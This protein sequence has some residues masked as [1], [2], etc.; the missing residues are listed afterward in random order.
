VHL[1]PQKNQ[2]FVECLAGKSV[3]KARQLHPIIC[4]FIYEKQFDREYPLFGEKVVEIFTEYKRNGTTYRAHPKYNSCGE[5]Y[6]WVMIRFEM[7]CQKKKKKGFYDNDLFLGKILCFLQSKNKSIDA[8]VH[9][10]MAS[11]HSDDG[12][13]V[14]RWNKEYQKDGRRFIPLL[15]CVS[16][17]SFE[18]PCFVVEDKPG[19]MESYGK[20]P[21]DIN[22]GVTL[23]K[24]REKA[25]PQAF[26]ENK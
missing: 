8:I 7:E 17:D 20:D 3:Q 18:E 15:R 10:C 25:W 24:P 11:D 21:D 26:F 12:I 4:D 22:N 23:V 14:E 16:V 1:N 5:W 19:L 13:L 2:E 9:C 6:D